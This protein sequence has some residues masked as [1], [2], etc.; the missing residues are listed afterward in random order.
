MSSEEEEIIFEAQKVH[1]NKWAEIAKLLKGRT[2][3]VVK[4]YFY[5]TLRRQL[6]KLSKK[7]SEEDISDPAEVNLAYMRDKMKQYNI[8]YSYLDNENIRKYLEWL[9]S[10]DT[11]SYT[12][13]AKKDTETTT[14]T[15][16]A[17]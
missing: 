2:D 16:Y 1:T 15:K 8:P 11:K 12:E 7:I 3:N 4:N 6:R 10:N 9:D 17:L 14:H 13:E 5:S